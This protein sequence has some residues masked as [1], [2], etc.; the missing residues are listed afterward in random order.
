MQFDLLFDNYSKISSF[1][2]TGFQF[3]GVFI[4]F[5]YKIVDANTYIGNLI[6]SFEL[7]HEV[8]NDY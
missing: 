2:V 1:K 7:K 5:Y 3:S 6:N 8:T 4:L